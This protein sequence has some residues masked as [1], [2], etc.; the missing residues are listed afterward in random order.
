MCKSGT[1]RAMLS[2]WQG[3][4]IWVLGRVFDPLREVK[5]KSNQFVLQQRCG[6][7]ICSSSE[8]LAENHISQGKP[9][10]IVSTTDLEGPFAHN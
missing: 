2:G 10:Q 3:S 4:G 7:T 9:R 5:T 8:M 1:L 6:Q